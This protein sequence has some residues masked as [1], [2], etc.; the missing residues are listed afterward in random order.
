[1]LH[2]EY[3]VSGFVNIIALDDSIEPTYKQLCAFQQWVKIFIISKLLEEIL[4]DLRG[5]NSFQAT[6][7][8]LSKKAAVVVVT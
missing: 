5:L 6:C 3:K 2:V 4:E 8:S 7:F 1:M